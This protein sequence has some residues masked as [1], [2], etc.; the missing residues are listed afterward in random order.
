[1][2]LEIEIKLRVDDLAEVRRRL[3]AAGARPGGA[4]LEVNTFLDTPDNRLQKE[5]SGLRVRRCREVESGALAC[6]ITFKGPKQAGGMKTREENE[7][8]VESY[9]AAVVLLGQL[10]YAV[11]LS[12]EK[13]REIWDLG[14]CEVVLDELP[15]DLGRFVEIEGPNEEVI[16]AV[17]VRLGLDGAKVEQAG[18]A[19]LV[20][21]RLAGSGRTELGFG[22]GDQMSKYMQ[23]S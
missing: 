2:G 17:Q 23:N 22:D 16:R 3:V 1:M 14:G 20:A 4:R 21:G 13:R 19:V 15:E 12:F 10:G 8:G 6:V 18:Y 5:G 7:F 11:K 9:D